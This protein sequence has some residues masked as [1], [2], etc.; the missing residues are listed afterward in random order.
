MNYHGLD[1]ENQRDV[2]LKN[3][4]TLEDLLRG[5]YIDRVNKFHQEA[6][7]ANPSPY[8]FY[9]EKDCSI[10][11]LIFPE[12]YNGETAATL[13]FLCTPGERKIETH[14]VSEEDLQTVDSYKYE[15]LFINEKLLLPLGYN[16]SEIF[17]SERSAI[18]SISETRPG[19]FI[20]KSYDIG[21]IEGVHRRRLTKIIITQLRVDIEKY[22]E[23]DQTKISYFAENATK[24]P[25]SIIDLN[26]LMEIVDDINFTYQLEQAMAAYR[27]NL[28]LPAAA[29]L[30]V[31][32][33]TVCEKMCR[34]N[35]ISVKGGET[36]LRK[37]I[38]LLY[39]ED[40]TKRVIT[41]R[42]NGRLEV[43]YKMR[44]MASH[45]SPGAVLRGDCHFMLNVIQDV[46]YKYLSEEPKE[47]PYDE[48]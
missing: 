23:I 5:Y 19:E 31:C 28:F 12:D 4:L 38:D 34:V 15:S 48:R 43:A 42:D 18:D 47:I 22:K 36:Q 41:R 21:Y 45:T 8:R 25:F 16:E 39:P 1:Q 44:N 26:P 24:F 9:Y 29:T 6:F 7:G 14:L 11:V 13:Y 32:L 17:Y 37:L 33:E 2:I 3:A 10:L 46:A 30:G 20:N 40:K 35:G 27:Q